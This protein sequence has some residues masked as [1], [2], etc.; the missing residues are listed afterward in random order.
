MYFVGLAEAGQEVFI[1]RLAP[2]GRPVTGCL[3]ICGSS[4]TVLFVGGKPQVRPHEI[5]PFVPEA[6]SD[7]RA[8]F[9][10]ACGAS[11]SS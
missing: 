10:P 9:V 5:V 2:T 8:G 3:G 7:A 1:G 4:I 11:S 6:F